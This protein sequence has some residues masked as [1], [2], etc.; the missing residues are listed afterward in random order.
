MLTRL[1]LFFILSSCFYALQAQSSLS[2][3]F[4][5]NNSKIEYKS[6]YEAQ[7]TGGILLQWQYTLACGN[8]NAILTQPI[9]VSIL[10]KGK[11][12]YSDTTQLSVLRCGATQKAQYFIPYRLLDLIDGEQ[13]VAG[14]LDLTLV[15]PDYLYWQTSELNF[16]QPYRCR[17]D[18]ELSNGAVKTKFDSWDK[19][20]IGKA[21]LPDSYYGIYL[22]NANTPIALSK[23]QTDTLALAHEKFSTYVLTSD[24]V[25]LKFFD[26][27]GRK[28]E[29]LA[30][31]QLPTCIGDATF[32]KY[33]EMYADIKEL[34]YT[35]TYQQMTQQPIMMY[36]YKSEHEGIKGVKIDVDYSVSRSFKD[37]LGK[38]NFVFLD[39]D[40]NIID[41]H[42][43]QPIA[44]THGS[45]VGPQLDSFAV[46]A[47]R[48]RWTY[49]IPF[50]AWKNEVAQIAFYMLTKNMQKATATPCILL[51]PIRFSEPL[52][53]ANISI[54]ENLRLL[55]ISGMRVN[56][57]YR[58]S[59]DFPSVDG[60]F[61]R[62][63]QGD[64]NLQGVYRIF[65]NGQKPVLLSDLQ[66]SNKGDALRFSAENN[67][68]KISLFIPYAMLAQETMTIG[69]HIESLTDIEVI[70]DTTLQI[71]LPIVG[72]EVK[73]NLGNVSDF[74]LQNDYGKVIQVTYQVPQ[75][76]SQQTKVHVAVKRNGELIDKFKI[77]NCDTCKNQA[78]N[79]EKDTGAIEIMLPYRYFQSRDS[80]SVETW[81]TH[82]ASAK[83]T[84]SDTVIYKTRLPQNLGTTD[85]A[86]IPDILQVD[87]N[88][89]PVN[90][91]ENTVWNLSIW[92]GS[93]QKINKPLIANKRYT[94]AELKNYET[95]FSAHR[96]DKISIFV[97]KQDSTARQALI[98]RG[99][100]N[101]LKKDNYK[102][103][104]EKKFPI[105]KTKWL[106]YPI[107]I[108]HKPLQKQFFKWGWYKA[109]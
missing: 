66:K 97:T 95:S 84:L 56:I 41:V 40:K 88:A 12:I 60:F 9:Q 36:A 85:Y 71:K 8:G 51:Q 43:V 80:I 96:R 49:F 4:N 15:I 82:K 18:F 70:K 54:E 48:E 50:Y 100:I 17:L 93:E 16:K 75:F 61:L 107:E 78:L 72:K 25:Y 5:I 68:D 30:N 83:R 14:S 55:N 19:G 98:W 37:Q 79:V 28:D 105:W 106:V 47:Q 81:I 10:Q 109:K 44:A 6:F 101:Q 67:P 42:K 103:K 27:D 45:K 7:G 11:V 59:E 24:S 63:K 108:M 20:E 38:I 58:I 39:A 74:A 57:D 21:A 2:N 104:V 46:L 22:G 31:I 26:E 3:K 53:Y 94:A 65:N 34:S 13:Y 69:A 90:G 77:I 33:G 92:L 35:L 102:I 99:D 29:L 89:L 62:I 32:N 52:Q 64:E 23:T 86:I 1:L 91:G 73:V 76:L 87:Q